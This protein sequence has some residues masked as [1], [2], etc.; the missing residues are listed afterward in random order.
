MDSG[1]TSLATLPSQQT[2][3]PVQMVTREVR[4][5]IAAS[6]QAYSP[7]APPPVDQKALL[8]GLESASAQG[9]TGL[10]SRDIPANTFSQVVDAQRQPSY[11][12]QPSVS[13]DYITE[14]QTN[15]DMRAVGQETQSYTLENNVFDEV[16]LPL[17]VAACYC[18][19]QMPAT[20]RF[21]KANLPFGYN[22][23]GSP[24]ALGYVAS[25]VV[26]GAAVYTG[27]RLVEYLSD[28]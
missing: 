19:F 12:P 9:L 5:E 27:V 26:F 23:L 14:H 6:P 11:V 20:R 3:D 10:P 13:H 15:E 7:Q 24:N 1:T 2:G 4:N 22:E 25:S 21:L 17:L 16:K 8:A 18:V 28:K